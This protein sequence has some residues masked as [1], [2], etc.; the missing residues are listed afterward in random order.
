MSEDI[1]LKKDR[2]KEG[3]KDTSSRKPPS[4]WI[5]LKGTLFQSIRIGLVSGTV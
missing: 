2:F 5:K 3:R 4:S 1:R